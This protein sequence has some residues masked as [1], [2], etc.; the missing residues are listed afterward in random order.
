[1]RLLSIFAMLLA[2]TLAKS[3]PDPR[4]TATWVTQ[5]RAVITWQ[6][7]A[8]FHGTTCLL[9]EYGAEWP[10]GICWR[11]LPSGPTTIELPGALTHPAYRPADGDRYVLSFDGVDMG[12][13]TLGEARV[14]RVYLGLVQQQ[15]AAQDEWRMW[16][17]WVGR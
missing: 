3:T 1:M 12:I 6:Q 9:R 17:P 5:G 2:T 13:A 4:L 8:D 15:R 16:L 14:Y 10:A 11:D 7:P